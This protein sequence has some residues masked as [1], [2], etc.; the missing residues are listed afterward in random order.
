MHVLSVALS[1]GS[2][3]RT[4]ASYACMKC[5][6]IYTLS[7]RSSSEGVIPGKNI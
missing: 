6:A 2:L 1:L 5:V 4:L 7:S 3:K